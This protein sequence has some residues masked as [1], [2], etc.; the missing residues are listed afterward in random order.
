MEINIKVDKEE[1]A[2]IGVSVLNYFLHKEATK[3]DLIAMATE[4]ITSG[5]TAM[6]TGMGHQDSEP[7]KN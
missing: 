5:L 1:L 4:R 6:V 2:D 7:S 3:K